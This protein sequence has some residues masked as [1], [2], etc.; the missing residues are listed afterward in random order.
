MT[1][2]TYWQRITERLDAFGLKAWLQRSDVKLHVKPLVEELQ[3]ERDAL[4][5][6]NTAL[7][8][9]LMNM[10]W[11]YMGDQDGHCS[12]SFMSAGE[13]CCEVLVEAGVATDTGGGCILNWAALE[14]RKPQRQTWAQAVA[15]LDAPPEEKARLLALDAPEPRKEDQ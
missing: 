6:G 3:A 15:E 8:E 14:A 12:H 11:Q 13:D 2:P 10:A 4:K 5:A 9:A 1:Q 7:I